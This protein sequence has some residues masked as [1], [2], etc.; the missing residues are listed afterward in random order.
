MPTAEQTNSH[1]SSTK[2]LN[3]AGNSR[4]SKIVKICQ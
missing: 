3:S 4:L 2:L 1:S